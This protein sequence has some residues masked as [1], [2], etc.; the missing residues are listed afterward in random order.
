M[1]WP[2]AFWT[3]LWCC[4]CCMRS[5]RIFDRVVCDCGFI[6]ITKWLDPRCFKINIVIKNQVR[7]KKHGAIETEYV[8]WAIMEVNPSLRYL[9]TCHTT[10]FTLLAFGRLYDVIYDKVRNDENAERETRLWPPWCVAS[11]AI[12]VGA[13]VYSGWRDLLL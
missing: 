8:H 2:R 10:M 6:R 9:C 1:I 12:N 13:C 3:L 7:L 5:K 4:N 11:K